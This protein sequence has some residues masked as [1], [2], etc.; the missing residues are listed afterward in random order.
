M[1]VCDP[2]KFVAIGLFAS[3]L[4]MAVQG[5]TT[6]APSVKDVSVKTVG[7]ALEARII[8]TQAARFTYFEL[9][10]PHRL[11]VDFHG[12]LN[13]VGFTEKRVEAG[14]LHRIRASN[15]SST[16]RTATRIVFDLETG[17]TYKVVDDGA[18]IVR[19]VFDKRSTS[20]ALRD[21]PP[22]TLTAGPPVLPALESK[23]A[24]LAGLRP[25]QA[26]LPIRQ[27]AALEPSAGLRG[28]SLVSAL[29]G[30]AL[31]Q[32]A[33]APTALPP[34][35]APIQAQ[36][37]SGESISLD[38]KDLDIKDF[39][40]L[41][42]KISGLNIVLDPNVSGTIP[43]LVMTDVPWDQ[44]LDVVL[45]NYSLG[46]Q[47]QGNV[48]RIAT[49]T[50][51]QAEETQRKAVRDAQA[52]STPLMVRNYV[53][54]YVKA[55]AA[56]T[57][58][59]NS[60]ML[61]SRGT[62]TAE[63]RRNAI[64][65]QDVPS[66]FDSIEQMKNFIDTPL[67]QVEIEARLLSANKSFSREIGSQI[68]MLLGANSGNMLTG[69]GGGSPFQRTPAPRAT[70]DGAGLPLISNLP[71]A[72]TSGLAFLMQPGSDVLID[73]IITAAEAN[74]TAK[75]I[76]RPKIMAQN[77]QPATVSQGTQIP[78]QTNVNNTISVS[79]LTF[80]LRLTVTPQITEAGTILTT[81]EV[82]N[83]QPD[84]ARSVNGIPSIAT[85]QAQTL[86]LIPDG[87]TAM[88]GGILVDTDSLNTR[89]VPGIGSLPIIGH[90]FKNTQT[91]KS[92]AELLFF[93]TP[94][95]KAPDALLPT[96]AAN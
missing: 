58:L 79:F 57:T 95:I 15:F 74:G 50:T 59:R 26:S 33:P 32:I 43:T 88:I 82:E 86:V 51:L 93:I 53:L 36:N 28:P 64:I 48:L 39:F 22:I 24:A 40:N 21:L 54:S 8:S 23:T 66:Q 3:T 29:I 1:R 30:P 47:L 70:I 34:I 18:G 6:A 17:A 90:L 19:V 67:Q 89:E 10:G 71:A 45:R 65:V 14:T 84:F 46:G 60:G 68:G 62:V 4:T 27:L 37:F 61:T 13:T 35:A 55:D 87:A 52:N 63:P 72:A 69:A 20:R 91:I 44:A 31:A 76:S 49:N 73:A 12:S 11:V 83:S 38:F 5:A 77:N 42:A 56:A 81:I 41:I 9:Q 16:E 2:R 75:L 96:P 85:Q 25:P 92:T 80:A 78:V 7:D 94:R